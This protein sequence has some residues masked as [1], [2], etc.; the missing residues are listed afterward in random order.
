MKS[1]P[2]FGKLV[3]ANIREAWPHEAHGFTPWLVNNL[4]PISEALGIRLELIDREVGV[5][6]YSAD[7]LALNTLDDTRVV[8]EN[9]LEAGN[10]NHL[11]QILTYLAGLEAKT[12]VWIASSFTDEHLLALQW[13][14]QHTEDGYSFF[15]IRVK[16]V[17]IGDS[18]Y[19]PIF[20]VLER[21]NEWERQLHIAAKQTEEPEYSTHRREFWQAFIDHI[22]GELERSGPAQALSNRW[23]E[24]PDHGVVISLMLS[25]GKI[26]IFYR[27]GRGLDFAELHQ[28][29][30]PRADEIAQKLGLPVERVDTGFYLDRPGDYADP[31]QRDQLINWMAEKAD[32]YERVFKGAFD[33]DIETREMVNG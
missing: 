21:P 27:N 15:A 23:R 17:R 1:T 28:R 7:I 26:G 11:G 9:Q 8:I 30:L 24:M 12:A 20:E 25:K 2:Q 6:R 18:P 33:H 31:E 5:G 32:L 10:H 14:N 29:L 16:V 19:A 4:E 13:L 22:P 3:E